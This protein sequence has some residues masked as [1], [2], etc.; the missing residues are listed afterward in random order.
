MSLQQ[1]GGGI[2]SP[3][4]SQNEADVLD[5]SSSVGD[6][7]SS[8]EDM[9]IVSVPFAKSSL[10]AVPHV[11][12]TYASIVTFPGFATSISNPWIK[13]THQRGCLAKEEGLLASLDA[14]YHLDFCGRSP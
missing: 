9:L 11:S 8:F 6:A 1:P 2:H 14:R 4:N 3:G 7:F 5:S 10:M 13:S 12:K